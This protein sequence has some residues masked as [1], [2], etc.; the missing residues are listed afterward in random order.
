[1]NAYIRPAAAFKKLEAAK[2]NRQN[3]YIS[4]STGFGKTELVKQ[5]LHNE[6]YIYIPCYQNSCDLSLIPVKNKRVATVVIDNVNAIESD[7]LRREINSL[8]ERSTLWV[9][10]IGRSRMPSWLYDAFI[11]NHMVLIPEEDLALTAENIDQYMRS[12]GLI[13]TPEE[14]SFLC[15]SS[16]GNLLGVKYTAQLLAAG[17]KISK[18]LY[19]ENSY[20][21]QA[22]LE[23]KIISE[24]SSEVV[25]FLLKISIVNEF[26][27]SLA[28][29]LTGNSSVYNL[30]ERTL[31]F[32]NFLDFNN[33]VYTLRN[34]MKETLRRKA[35]KE[36]SENDLHHFALLA[37]GYYE[38]QGED[39]KA[40]QLYAQYN[41][42]NRIRDLLIKN[43]RRNPGSGYFIEMQK[44]YLML[45]DDDIRSHIHL[46]SAMSMLYS[47][48][49]DF[50]KSEYWYNEL[51]QYK[52]TVKGSKQREAICQ[53]AYLDVGLPGRGSINILQLIQ[54]CYV[55]L[56]KESISVPEF[57]VTSNL[58][59]VMN[60]GKDFC[61]WSKHDREI[62]ATAGNIISAFL[63]KFGK[64]LVNAALAESFYE[65]GG[66]PFEIISLVSKAK[67]EAE[68]GGKIEL[69]FAATATLI[70]QYLCNGDFDGAKE[71][72]SSFETIAHREGLHKLFANIDAMKCRLALYAN[73]MN[74]VGEWM[75]KAPDENSGFITLNRYL[76]LTKIRCY[77]AQKQHSKAIALIESMKYYAER[78]DRKYIDM[79]LGILKSVILYREN[80]EWKSEFIAALE[81]ICEYRFIPIIAK[82]GAAV[83][84]LLKQ[85]AENCKGNKK[86]NADWLERVIN[87]TGKIARFYPT[88]LK[89]TPNEFIKFQPMDVRTLSCLADGMSIQETAEALNIKYETLRSRVKELYRKLNAK[90]KTEAVLTARSLKLI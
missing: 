20:L 1:M 50:D 49:M 30:I 34:H 18:E 78:C 40:L 38:S 89:E 37:G 24:L 41:E 27:A 43:S 53:I 23:N 35:A 87:E 83:Y 86:I 39:D 31:D 77:I 54:D 19:E 33:G 90:N 74:T 63:G 68:S 81:K 60:G 85:C 48:M 6:K 61:E 46:M 4:G 28:S 29:M 62:A 55:L 2:M 76:Y 26:T 73:D 25:D 10:I 3:V 57:S 58:P 84:D 16:E 56:S 47:M 14:L 7:I 17:K 42:T 9:I 22:Y 59:S 52:N 11:T 5:F 36:L 32:G 79:E 8:C 70:R 80:S 44:Y 45:S 21:F 12:E 64:G 71:L 75:K 67:L 15:E 88:Y 72:L 66:D 69:Q 13:L 65:K 51:K 82:E